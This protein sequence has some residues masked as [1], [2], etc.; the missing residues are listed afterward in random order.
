MNG[1]ATCAIGHDDSDDLMTMVLMVMNEYDDNYDDDDIDY[2]IH[3]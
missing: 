1:E 2:D 3:D